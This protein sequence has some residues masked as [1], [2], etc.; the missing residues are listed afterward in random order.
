MENLLS[1][2]GFEPTPTFVDQNTPQR[3]AFQAWVWR[4][5][6]LGQPDV[7][8]CEMREFIE[9]KIHL[10]RYAIKSAISQDA[11]RLVEDT[12]VADHIWVS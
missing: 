11:T 7:I 10:A 5:R 6:P 4:L 2:V 1:E 9:S 3:E 12:H 8:I